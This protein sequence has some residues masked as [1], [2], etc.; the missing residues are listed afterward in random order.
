M[1]RG[2]SRGRESAS[3]SVDADSFF[4]VGAERKAE[5]KERQLCRQV[6]EALGVALAA[7]R[8]PV[9]Q[10]LWVLDVEPA[11]DASR[12]CI[13]L[14][15][16]GGSRVDEILGRLEGA[17]GYLRA[18]VASAITRKRTPTLTYRVVLQEEP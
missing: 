18:E 8:D 3:P 13:V 11:P 10:D 9:L 5:R 15:A 2:R 4:A 12:L 16:P 7:Q 17:A 14:G 6:H 1:K